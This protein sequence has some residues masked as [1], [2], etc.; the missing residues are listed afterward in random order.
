[1]WKSWTDI[2][3]LLGSPCVPCA[4]PYMCMYTTNIDIL[5][6]QQQLPLEIAIRNR[7]GF[8]FHSLSFNILKYHHQRVIW[9]GFSLFDT[10]SSAGK[11]ANYIYASIVWEWICMC[12]WKYVARSGTCHRWYG[13]KLI[14]KILGLHDNILTNFL[15]ETLAFWL[16]HCFDNF[17]TLTQTLF[18]LLRVN[19]EQI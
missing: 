4:I 17:S 3:I 10:I 18:F 16:W 1:M 8:V 7:Y 9:Y 6:S 2:Y 11:H 13:F 5:S 14:L 19:Y 15:V 12:A